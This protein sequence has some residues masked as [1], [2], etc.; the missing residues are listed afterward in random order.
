MQKRIRL[1]RMLKAGDYDGA[2]LAG[3][4]DMVY[5]IR[6]QGVIDK[7]YPSVSEVRSAIDGYLKEGS[8]DDMIFSAVLKAAFS[9]ERTD[10]PT[11]IK[12]TGRMKELV[13]ELAKKLKINNKRDNY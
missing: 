8:G 7:D 3:Y 11:Y 2:L 4:R 10:E 13:E 12:V 5:S 9:K 6:K 1:G